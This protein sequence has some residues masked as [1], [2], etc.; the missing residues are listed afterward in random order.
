MLR[1]LILIWIIGELMAS[2]CGLFSVALI[3][4]PTAV[5]IIARC[6]KV[7][8][9]LDTSPTRVLKV[10]KEVQIWTRYCNQNYMYLSAP[11]II[12]FG[13]CTLIFTNY[14]T[15]KFPGKLPL[16]LYL[17]GPGTSLAGFIVLLTLLPQATLVWESSKDF[18]GVLK[19][20]CFSKY[21]LR[22]FRSVSKVGVAIGPFGYATKSWMVAI[23]WNIVNYSINFLLTF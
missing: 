8:E 12:F 5:Q 1:I 22:L 20:K 15:I 17:L 6:R 2:I 9:R 19:V 11:P 14:M 18:L 13:M 21:E 16:P 10:Y 23:L 7:V 3:L 4:L